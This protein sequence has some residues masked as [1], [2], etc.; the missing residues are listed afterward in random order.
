MASSMIK[1]L[2]SSGHQKGFLVTQRVWNCMLCMQRSHILCIQSLFF[3]IKMRYMLLNHNH[4]SAISKFSF[5][6]SRHSEIEF[7]VLYSSS[8]H[9]SRKKIVD[10]WQWSQKVHITCVGF[11]GFFYCYV[12]YIYEPVLKWIL[13]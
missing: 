5:H 6:I 11:F 10:S 13:L 7:A 4:C 12:T 2:F 9:T 8:I 3:P 1:S